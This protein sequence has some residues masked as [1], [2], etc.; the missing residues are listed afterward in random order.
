MRSGSDRRGGQCDVFKPVGRL[1]HSFSCAHKL[2]R[3]AESSDGR[4]ICGSF[5]RSCEASAPA[6]AQYRSSCAASNHIHVSRWIFADKLKLRRPNAEKLLSVMTNR[7]ARKRK[8]K[9]LKNRQQR[10]C[11]THKHFRPCREAQSIDA[12]KTELK[13][14]STRRRQTRAHEKC[15][16]SEGNVTFDGGM[17]TKSKGPSML[18]FGLGVVVGIFIGIFLAAS[19]PRELGELFRL[20]RSRDDPVARTHRC[21]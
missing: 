6:A 8:A 7:F 11:A 4:R 5:V 2:E 21:S 12:T 10:R 15:H 9:A 20:A 14:C 1:R 19:L 16:I 13:R 18:K 3:V 17:Q